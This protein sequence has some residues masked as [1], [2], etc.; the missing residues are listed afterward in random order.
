MKRIALIA[1]LRVLLATLMLVLC[2]LILA[3]SVC[4]LLIGGMVWMGSWFEV[5]EEGGGFIEPFLS[6]LEDL[7]NGPPEDWEP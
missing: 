7:E 2:P 3:V 4:C 5:V 6:A 1:G